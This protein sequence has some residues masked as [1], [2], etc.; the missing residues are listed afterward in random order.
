M[1]EDRTPSRLRPRRERAVASGFNWLPPEQVPGA[2]LP[3]SV[4]R[5]LQEKL[6]RFT[7][8]NQRARVEGA[9]YVIY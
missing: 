9:S 7:E 3:A 8:H 4:Q 1:T 2:I 6:R 5:E